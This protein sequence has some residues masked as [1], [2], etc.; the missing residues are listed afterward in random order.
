MF[1]V[2]SLAYFVCSKFIC[3]VCKKMWFILLRLHHILICLLI[4]QSVGPCALMSVLVRW[5]QFP[6]AGYDSSFSLSLAW[7]VLWGNFIHLLG[8]FREVSFQ[9]F[10]QLLSSCFCSAN[11]LSSK[12][13]CCCQPPS[14]GQL[15]M[16]SVYYDTLSWTFLLQF[17]SHLLDFLLL[18]IL[19]K[20]QENFI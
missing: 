9:I 11:S 3:V 18:T 20:S 17:K 1:I 2:S 8:F 5:W 12:C 15:H 19:D 16:A 7:L 6:L 10:C 4:Q 13:G 14:D